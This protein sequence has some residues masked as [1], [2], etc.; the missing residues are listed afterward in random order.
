MALVYWS[1]SL[2]PLSRYSLSDARSFEPML[3]TMFD[4]T[5]SHD[6]HGSSP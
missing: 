6:V 3:D 2:S 1:M 5:I 4:I